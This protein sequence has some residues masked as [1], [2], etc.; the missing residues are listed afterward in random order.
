[1]SVLTI[2]RNLA[3][4][5]RSMCECVR[6]YMCEYIRYMGDYREVNS[7]GEYIL[8]MGGALRGVGSP[9]SNRSMCECVRNY[10]WVNIW[11]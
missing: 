8:Y 11:V 3:S 5:K 7:V 2:A 6:N 10:I 9:S 4:S 1:M